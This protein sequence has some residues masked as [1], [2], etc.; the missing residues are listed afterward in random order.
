MLAARRGGRRAARSDRRLVAVGFL[1]SAHGRIDRHSEDPY[2]HDV[3]E[4]GTGLNS[5]CPLG[6][7]YQA[8]AF[9]LA[10]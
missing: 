2:G 5:A 3:Q 7:L 1:I 4:G 9:G 10:R 8:R 6:Y